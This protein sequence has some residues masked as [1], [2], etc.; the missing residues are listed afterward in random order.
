[1]PPTFLDQRWSESHAL[2]MDV[3]QSTAPRGGVTSAQS[4]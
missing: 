3:E 4:P 1:M 2:L